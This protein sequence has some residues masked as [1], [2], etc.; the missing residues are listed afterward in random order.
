MHDSVFSI[1][2]SYIYVLH[3]RTFAFLQGKERCLT[4]L[5]NELKISETEHAECLVKARS[6]RQIKSFR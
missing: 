3:A 4:E 2:F 1:F 5:R 6:N